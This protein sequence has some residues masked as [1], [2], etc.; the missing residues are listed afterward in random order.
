MLL[1]FLRIAAVAIGFA[2]IFNLSQQ[3]TRA[4]GEE[5]VPGISWALG[6]ISLIFAASAVISERTRGPE[7]NLQKDV[8]WGLAAGSVITIILRF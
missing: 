2:F 7:A 8:L 1:R 3:V 4:R 5:A 6:V